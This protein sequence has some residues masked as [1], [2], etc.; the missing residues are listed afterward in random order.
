MSLSCL[1]MCEFVKPKRR[2]GR[3]LDRARL[4]EAHIF[5]MYAAFIHKVKSMQ[6]FLFK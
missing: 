4:S 6:G 5:K 3:Y 2:P 1:Q